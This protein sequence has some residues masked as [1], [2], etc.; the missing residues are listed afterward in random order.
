MKLI[1]IMKKINLNPQVIGSTHAVVNKYNQLSLEELDTELVT[2]DAIN[3]HNNIPNF[4][5]KI[6][7]KK[8]TVGT[9][10]YLQTLQLKK[11]CRVMLTVNLDVKDSLSNGSIGTFMGL[12]KDEHTGVVRAL[13]VHFDNVDSGEEMRR[14]HPHLVSNFPNCTPILKQA[15]KYST[16]KTSRGVKSNTATVFQF[17]LIL[18]FA[19]TTHKIQVRRGIDFNIA[20][21][22]LSSAQLSWSGYYIVVYIA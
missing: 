11:G 19:S 9:T 2:I 17:P 15:H 5:P 14:C 3:S 8:H 22:Q 18:S 12:V 6:H 16:A 7:P 1:I 10:S 20:Q 21:L 13:M 4:R